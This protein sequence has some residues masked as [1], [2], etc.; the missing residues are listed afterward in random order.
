MSVPDPDRTPHGLI[1]VARACHTGWHTS[2]R[3]QPPFV[4][5]MRQSSFSHH[6]MVSA[7]TNL[8]SDKA[9]RCCDLDRFKMHSTDWKSSSP[10]SSP[11]S[12]RSTWQRTGSS[13]SSRSAPLHHRG[14]DARCSLT[15]QPFFGKIGGGAPILCVPGLVFVVVVEMKS[16]EW[17]GNPSCETLNHVYSLSSSV[18]EFLC[19][20]T[21]VGKPSQRTSFLPP[22]GCPCCQI[23]V[24][25]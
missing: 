13:H 23:N 9:V 6:R 20:I 19:L 4:F 16:L 3:I 17:M 24:F 8:V 2:A 18:L 7:Q 25:V 15:P 5:L 22:E 12:W 10:P 1:T 11:P 21:P 14:P